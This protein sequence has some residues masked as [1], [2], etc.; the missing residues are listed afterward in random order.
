MR[1]DVTSGTSASLLTFLLYLNDDFGGGET[2][3]FPEASGAASPQPEDSV[4]CAT[5]TKNYAPWQAS[6]SR[7]ATKAMAVPSRVP[8]HPVQGS[9]LVFPQTCELGNGGVGEENLFANSKSPLHEG[10]IVRELPGGGGRPKYVM[11]SD[12]LYYF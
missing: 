4:A 7:R 8:V 3:F 2:A 10:S 9:V 5:T 6:L 11:R 12:V 1:W